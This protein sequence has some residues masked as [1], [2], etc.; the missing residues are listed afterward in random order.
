MPTIP[1]PTYRDAILRYW[2]W[3]QDG[4][5]ARV[6]YAMGTQFDSLADIL[7]GGIRARFPGVYSDESLPLIGRERRIR[8]GLTE[9]ATAYAV[10]LCGWLDQHPYRG[11]PYALLAQL[12]AFLAPDYQIDLQYRSG[13]RFV[14]DPDGTVTRSLS[15]VV[16]TT[17]WCRWTLFY[18]TDS[19]TYPSTQKQAEDLTI[20]PK[21]W[22][23]AHCSGRVLVMRTG[24]EL[25]DYPPGHT[26]DESGTWNTTPIIKLSI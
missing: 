8:R 6:L 11:N 26:W 24:A 19:I 10:R 23:A 2:P 3:S 14:L 20:V 18:F 22:N 25:W 4:N 21:E 9:S 12:H 15:T 5:I 17:S 16:P 7:V 1:T 13:R